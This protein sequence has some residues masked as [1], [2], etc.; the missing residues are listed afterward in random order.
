MSDDKEKL[1]K[2]MDKEFNR[3]NYSKV[4]KIANKILK[5]NPNEE[6]ASSLKIFSLLFLGEDNKALKFFK[7]DLGKNPDV[8]TIYEAFSVLNIENKGKEAFKII[9]SA[10]NE[11]PEN[12]NITISLIFALIDLNGLKSGFEFI[13]NFPKENSLWLDVLFTKA[14]LFSEKNM[15]KDSL[16]VCNEILSNNPQHLN[17]LS[18]KVHV[19]NCLKR[20][21]ET[22]EIIDYRIKNNLRPEWAMVDK[23]FWFMNK[24]RKSEAN[25]ILDEVLEK[26]P[27]FGYALANKAIIASENGMFD[28]ALKYINKALKNSNIRTYDSIMINKA[29]IL[30]RKGDLDKS[31]N[32]LAKINEYSP[33]WNIAQSLLREYLGTNIRIFQKLK[34]IF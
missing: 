25:E 4:I 1:L 23:A 14:D 30:F 28:S 17:A 5:I 21:D 13:D 29:K 34:N 11:N 16:K 12:K 27:N 32:I 8:D 24:N 9:Q 15:F 19:L 7:Q 26:D 3:K 22:L 18:K 20:G 10:F 31:L 6:R 2:R 33:Q